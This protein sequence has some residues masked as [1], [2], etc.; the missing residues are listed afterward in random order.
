MFASQHLWKDAA[1]YI[2]PERGSDFVQIVFEMIKKITTLAGY[3]KL[4]FIA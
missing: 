3:S 4:D 1:K 2:N